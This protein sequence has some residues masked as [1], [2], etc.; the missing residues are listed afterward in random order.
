MRE[1]KRETMALVSGNSTLKQ[2][3]G[4]SGIA[5]AGKRT[6]WELQQRRDV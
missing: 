4:R 6:A 2:T 1:E 5:R 3:P